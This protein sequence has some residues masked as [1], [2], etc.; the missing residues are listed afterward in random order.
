MN[1]CFLKSSNGRRPTSWLFTSMVELLSLEQLKRK[2]RELWKRFSNLELP[3]YEYHALTQPRFLYWLIA[4]RH[5]R[6]RSQI[7]ILHFFKTVNASQVRT[8]KDSERRFQKYLSSK[9]FAHGRSSGFLQLKQVWIVYPYYVWHFHIPLDHTNHVKAAVIRSFV[10]FDIFS[11][12]F[13][14]V[15]P[16]PIGNMNA[17]GSR[18]LSGG[19]PVNISTTVQP[20]LLYRK[21]RNHFFET[22]NAS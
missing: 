21:E 4:S 14:S 20:T 1:V 15:G 5:P 9:S 8:S 22:R 6:T 18:S 10:V 2:F 17:V 7:T 11:G 13:G 19:F 12:K 16:G 3:G